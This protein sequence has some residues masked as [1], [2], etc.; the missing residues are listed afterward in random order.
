MVSN[1]RAQQTDALP[2]RESGTRLFTPATELAPRRREPVS[3]MGDPEK[4]N[5]NRVPGS[6]S[7]FANDGS[8]DRERARDNRNP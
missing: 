5:R 6:R 4:T 7:T 8:H 1:F 3:R 2:F